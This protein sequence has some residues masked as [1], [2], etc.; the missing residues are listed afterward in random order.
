MERLNEVRCI[1]TVGQIKSSD[2]H[3]YLAIALNESYKRDGDADWVKKTVWLDVAAFGLTR[4]KILKSGIGVGDTV[5]LLAK[6]DQKEYEGKK[7][8]QMLAQKVILL[9]KSDKN[10]S[11]VESPET[12]KPSVD[13]DLPF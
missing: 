5:L 6:L 12:T 11:D 8:I 2:K 4:E 9:Q 1:G 13:D 10:I 3:V 7:S